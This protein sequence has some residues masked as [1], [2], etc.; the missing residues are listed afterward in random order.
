MSL[1]RL[2]MEQAGELGPSKR[3]QLIVLQLVSCKTI[4]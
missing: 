3:L 2:Y 1:G 4:S